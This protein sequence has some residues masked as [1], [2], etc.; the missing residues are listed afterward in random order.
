MRES[1]ILMS[2]SSLPSD[3]GIGCFSEEAYRFIDFLSD[4]GQSYWQILPMGHTGFGDSPYQSF[5]SFAGNPYFIDLTRLIDRDVLDMTD[6]G[7]DEA[8]IDYGKLYQSR[9][10]ILHMAYKNSNFKSESGYSAFLRKNEFWLNDYAEFMALKDANNGKAWIEWE[11]LSADDKDIDFWKFV[12]YM[13]YTQWYDL[14][15]Y[16]NKKGIKIIGDIPIYVSYDSVDVWKNP[17]LFQ[18]DKNGLPIKV[19]GCPPDGFSATGQLWGNPLY[20]WQTHEN[21]GFSWWIKRIEY[22]F[23]LY[24]TL[25]IDHFRGFCEYYAIPYGAKTAIEGEWL[26]AP[27][28]NLFRTVENVLGKRDIIAEDLGFITE[29]VRELLRECGFCGMKVFEFAF[30]ERDDNGVEIYMPHNYP[31]NCVAYTETHDNEPVTSWFLGL[32]KKEKKL[33]REYLCD[34]YTPDGEIALPFISRI[35]QSNAR[36]C[37]IPI[38]DYLMLGGDS[39]MNTPQSVGGNW[40]W[41]IK[42]NQL[43]D[44]LGKRIL[45]MTKLYGRVQNA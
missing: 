31:K 9:Y 4:S 23:R 19:S 1:G 16:A 43:S 17:H 20:D 14:K 35:M 15:A 30:D 6:F 36:L 24:D 12:Q 11:T 21:D 18:L 25:R 10:A 40:Q 26:K 34:Y 22:S 7:V 33:V 38:Q 2:I 39:R 37:V 13:F 32:S 28:H 42:R 3:Y 41:R 29:S 45:S 27:G 44:E 5:S 8:R